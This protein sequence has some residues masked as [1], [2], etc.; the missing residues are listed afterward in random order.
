MNDVFDIAYNIFMIVLDTNVLVSA[1]RSNTGFS[2]RLLV[3]VLERRI[4]AAVSVPLFIEYEDVLSR[5]AHL[6]AFG[7]TT[8][9]VHRFLDGLAGVLSPVEISYLWRPQLKDPAD[10]MVLEAAANATA[11]HIVTWNIKDFAPVAGRFALQV[12]TPPQWFDS[13]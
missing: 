9:E 2:R 1:L 4:V 12:V 5:P 6:K 11:T 10:E 13:R 8:A 7:L 3:H